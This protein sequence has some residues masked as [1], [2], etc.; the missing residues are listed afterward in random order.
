MES[1]SAY[2]SRNLVRGSRG[3]RTTFK[4]T[5]WPKPQKRSGVCAA[6]CL[7]VSLTA[8]RWI[9]LGSAEVP[10]EFYHKPDKQFLLELMAVTAD[11]L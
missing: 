6:Q 3:S 11:A 9:H 2:I 7:I 8:G 10:I 4:R 1:W 5:S